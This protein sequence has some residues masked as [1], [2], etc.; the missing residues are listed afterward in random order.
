ML[1]PK[2]DL[3]MRR[4]ILLVPLT[5]AACGGSSSS[6][7]SPIPTSTPTPA[8]WPA[9]TSLAV[10]SGETGQP[11]TAQVLVSGAPYLGGAVA[12]GA[13]VQITAAGFIE[14]ATV[15]RT[16]ETALTLWPDNARLPRAY[17]K[18]LVFTSSATS[19][20]GSDSPMQRMPSRVRSVSLT[21]SAEVKA[22]P[23]AVAVMQAAVAEL[24]AAFGGRVAYSLDA[25]SADFK[26]SAKVDPADPLCA[27]ARG[28]SRLW[29]T[30]GEITRAELV[31]CSQ[32]YTH[33][34]GTAIHEL[35]HTAGLEHSEDRADVMYR[36]YS[37]SRVPTFTDRERLVLALMWQRRPGTVWPDNDSGTTASGSRIVVQVD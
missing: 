14:R 24:S 6:G 9:G 16:G 23:E 12:A 25:A 11:V 28:V 29:V 19:D 35:G 34:A 5:L 4:L 8:G 15:V 2:G 1:F 10:T 26:I 36:S 33:A 22:D 7:P 17:T 37:A 21:L 18:A 30:A 32:E 27:N 3:N 13:G 31:F 20:I